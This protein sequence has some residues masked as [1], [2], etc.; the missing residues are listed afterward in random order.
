MADAVLH[1]REPAVTG[2]DGRRVLEAIHAIYRAS[3]T[4]QRV[5]LPLR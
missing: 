3:E 1:D 2:E 4:G 5:T